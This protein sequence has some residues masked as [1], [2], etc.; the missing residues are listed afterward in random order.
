VTEDELVEFF[1]EKLR[2][3]IRMPG[4]SCEYFFQGLLSMPVCAK[5]GKATRERTLRAA[6]RLDRANRRRRLAEWRLKESTKRRAAP[7][8]TRSRTRT[9]RGRLNVRA[10]RTV[11]A[12]RSVR[13]HARTASGSSP[14][15][16]DPDPDPPLA[17]DRGGGECKRPARSMRSGFL[18][19]PRGLRHSYW[20][21]PLRCRRAS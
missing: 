21:L 10:P 18:H 2:E 1:K 17:P 6:R 15:G 16:G 20:Q 12:C 19:S 5:V 9:P 4:D 8:Q 3:I 14:P 7:R 13:A 11:R